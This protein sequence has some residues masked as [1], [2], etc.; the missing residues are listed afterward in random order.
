MKEIFPGLYQMPLILSGFDPGSVN[1]Y[2]IKTSGGLTAVDTG[3]DLPEALHSLKAQLSEIGA[4]I[5]DIKEVILTHFHIDHMGLVPRLKQ[6]QNVKVYLHQKELEL[7]KIRYTGRDN[8]LPLTDAFLQTHGFPAAELTPP[9]FQ[10]PMPDHMDSIVP[11]V[12]LQGGEEIS[13]GD[14]LFKIINTPGHTPGHIAL[15]EARNKFLISGDMLLPSIATNAAFHVQHIDYPLQKYLE[16]L[17]NLRMLDFD[18]VLPGHEHV[19]H[20]PRQRIDELIENQAKKSGQ[21]LRAF[22]DQQ[23]RTAFQISQS[24]AQSR[25]SG[26]SKWPEMTG[27]EKRFAV[28]QTIAHLESLEFNHKLLAL[29][30]GDIHYFK[31]NSH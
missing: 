23:P 4:Q 1:L 14:Y 6:N 8:F 7:M 13:V 12:L 2:L 16:S 28:L 22:N 27:W 11:N 31:T 17:K 15:F 30:I 24:L 20:N 29:Q 9:E 19:F 18:T 21:I 25:H 26:I 5:N 3:W 10:L